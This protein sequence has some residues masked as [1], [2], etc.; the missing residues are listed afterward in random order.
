MAQKIPE[1]KT[2]PVKKRWVLSIWLIPL[3]ALIV[4]GW[5]AWQYFSRLGPEIIIHF[6]SSGGLIANQSQIRFRDVPIGLVKKISLESGK[7]GVIVTARMNKD[8]APYLNDTSRFWI[9][10]ARIDTSGVQGLDT[11]ISG[12]YIELYAQPDEEHEKREFEGLDA[13]YIPA[14]LKG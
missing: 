7:E 11:L 5:F 12:T 4:S 2:T 6:K 10:K 8:A 3:L 9:V 1:V 13:P 14:T